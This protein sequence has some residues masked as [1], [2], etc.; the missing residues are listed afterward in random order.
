MI[1]LL[2]TTT[3]GGEL[4]QQKIKISAA[5]GGV[6]SLT[7]SRAEISYFYHAPQV[8]GIKKSL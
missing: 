3:S 4:T 2:S 8:A 7:S 6:L 5:S 1:I